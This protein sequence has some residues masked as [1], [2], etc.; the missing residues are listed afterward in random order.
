MHIIFFTLAIIGLGFLIFIH[1]LGHYF[2]AKRAGMRIQVFSIGFGKPFYSWTKNGV[3]WQFCYCLLGGYVKIAGM[4]KEGRTPPHKVKGGFYSKRPSS[5]IA[6]AFAGPLVNIIFAFLIFCVIF[7]IGGRKKSFAEY[8]QLIGELDPKSALYEKGVR[9]GDQID[10]F[11]GKPYSGIRDMQYVMVQ[12][13]TTPIDV[14]GQ[15]I[16]YSDQMR[17][18]FNYHVL[19]YHDPRVFDQDIYTLGI[20]TPASYLIYNAEKAP[21]PDEAPIAKSGI[22]SGDR[23]IWAGGERIFSSNQLEKII[24]EPVALL[25]IQRSSQNML[26]RVP[27]FSISAIRTS[28][29]FKGELDDWA[30]ASNLKGRLGEFKFIPYQVS[31]SATVERALP[32]IDEMAEQ[33]SMW[34]GESALQPGDRIL[35][36]NGVNIQTSTQLIDNLQKRQVQVIVKRNSLSKPINWKLADAQFEHAIDQNALSEITTALARGNRLE[37]SGDIALLKPITP[38]PYKDFPVSETQKKKMERAQELNQEKIENID[39]EQA[40]AEAQKMLDAYTGRLMLGVQLLDQAVIYNPTPWKLFD[41]TLDDMGR[42]FIGLFSGTL[43]PKYVAGPVGIVQIL[44]RSMGLG[45]PEALFWLALI[46]LNLGILNLLPIPPFDGGHIVFSL[47]EGVSGKRISQKAMDRIAIAFLILIA[48]FALYVTYN[49][50]FRLVGK[51]F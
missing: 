48:A 24:N 8:T 35:S 39:D 20:Y 50:V 19:P 46:S 17:K 18:P 45:I 9:A 42:T 29:A 41:D 11:D 44:H 38:I 37:S 10:S 28:S 25:S 1:E 40:R 31:S 6:V 21:I 43:S 14:K 26:V 16:D 34:V 2:I 23:I 49:D 27:I 33:Q 12:T 4:Q 30:H 13:P 3:R 15:H 47:I 7:A 32:Y 36:V 5:R 51:F 22:Q